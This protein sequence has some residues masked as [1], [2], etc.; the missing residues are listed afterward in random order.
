MQVIVEK[1]ASKFLS[2]YGDWLRE[3][4]VEHNLIL[5]LLKRANDGHYEDIIC[6]AV[7]DGEKPIQ[8][9]IQTPPH[10]L[11]LSE[12]DNTDG[13][14]V[15]AK[16]VIAQD[17]KLPGLVGPVKLVEEFSK[18]TDTVFI[19]ERGLLI[20]SLDKVI[21]PKD[22]AGEFVLAEDKDIDL[23]AQWDFDFA[24]EVL[25]KHEQKSLEKHKEKL[26]KKSKQLALWVVDGT[27]VSMV[28]FADSNGIGR[29]G[30]VYTPKE[31]RGHG[32]AS[33]ITALASQKLLDEGCEMCCLYTDADNPTSN[34]IYQKI[35]YKL[36]TDAINYVLKD[37]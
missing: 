29:V 5:N 37:A 15:L 4:L 14:E 30:P 12:A 10:N 2:K 28:G 9:A 32:Y 26:A 34:S 8:I 11:A 25:P 35:G 31:Y 3:N 36:C 19:K 17:L 33:V 13:L 16:E 7:L 21:M 18:L 20:Y 23:L 27:P 6:F 1:D 22:M 24:T